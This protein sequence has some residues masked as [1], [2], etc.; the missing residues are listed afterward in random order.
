ML[1]EYQKS[2]SLILRAWNKNLRV[3]SLVF[4]AAFS[5]LRACSLNKAQVSALQIDFKEV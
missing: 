2:C 3:M 1:C 5:A 4:K